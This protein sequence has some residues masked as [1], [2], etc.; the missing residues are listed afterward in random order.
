MKK[1]VEYKKTKGFDVPRNTIL[2]VF[3]IILAIIIFYYIFMLNFSTKDCQ[4]LDCYYDAL[5]DCD[6]ASVVREDSKAVWRYTIYG[7]Q[8]DY[9]CGVLVE[10]LTIKEGHVDIKSLEG[11]EMICVVAKGNSVLPEKKITSC[12]GPLREE[13]QYI[14]LQRLHKYVIDNLGEIEEEL[15]IF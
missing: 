5:Q 4:S 14:L 9:T 1:G 2:F 12:T 11:K 10:L 13:L 3:L 8:N 7:K 15:G 6:K